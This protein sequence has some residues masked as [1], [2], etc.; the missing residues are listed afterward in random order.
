VSSLDKGPGEPIDVYLYASGLA[1]GF[2]QGRV[3]KTD[4]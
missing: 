2:G 3:E 1:V 4:A